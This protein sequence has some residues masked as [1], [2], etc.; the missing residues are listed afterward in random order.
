MTHR[1]R[2]I[3]EG[4]GSSFPAIV[5]GATLLRE[6]NTGEQPRED[7]EHVRFP[8][9]VE[10]HHLDGLVDEEGRLPPA[11]LEDPEAAPPRLLVADLPIRE[12]GQ[13]PI[14]PEARHL[15]VVV[16]AGEPNRFTAAGGDL[17]EI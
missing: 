8:R 7:H 17:P 6:R 14:P 16:P 9:E 15:V 5:V 10:G 2:A 12:E 3:G 13:R 1:K 11:G 4:G